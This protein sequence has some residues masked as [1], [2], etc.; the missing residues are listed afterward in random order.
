LVGWSD[1]CGTQGAQEAKPSK[2]AGTAG[3]APAPPSYAATQRKKKPTLTAVYRG[4]ELV[5][6]RWRPPK[7]YVVNFEFF[8][9]S[10]I[11]PPYIQVLDM[12]FHYPERADLFDDV[13][14]GIHPDSRLAIVGPNGVGKSTLLN[15]L[16]GKLVPTRGEVRTK[17]GLRIGI[18]AQ[19]FVDLLVMDETPTEYLQ[20]VR[21]A[22]Q[23]AEG[24]KGGR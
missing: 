20:R 9:T 14:F 7:E 5:G 2:G 10:S 1:A 13:N 12:G 19:H 3:A 23:P 21:A 24:R 15:L 11:E 18:Y 8:E 16:T 17:T 22:A 6:G 4:G